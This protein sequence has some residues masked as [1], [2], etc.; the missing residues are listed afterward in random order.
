MYG[1]ILP[2][3]NDAAWLLAEFFGKLIKNKGSLHSKPERMPDISNAK[4][5]MQEMNFYAR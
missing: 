5:F 4:Y 3:G 2:S 1:L